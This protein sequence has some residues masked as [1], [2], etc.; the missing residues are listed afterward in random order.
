MPRR[1]HI[2]EKVSQLTSAAVVKSPLMG[3]VKRV[4]RVVEAL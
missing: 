1:Y 4:E 3:F 2:P